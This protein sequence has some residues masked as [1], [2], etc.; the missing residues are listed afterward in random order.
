MALI[1][2]VLVD[3]KGVKHIDN[4]NQYIICTGDTFSKLRKEFNAIKITP[5]NNPDI[6]YGDN[7][8]IFSLPKDEAFEVY[9]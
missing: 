4:A 9:I 5:P 8:R 1:S 7:L 6:S 3:K 2:Y